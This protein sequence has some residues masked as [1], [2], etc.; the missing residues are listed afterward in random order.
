MS[1]ADLTRR[2]ATALALAALA[3]PAAAAKPAAKSP[4]DRRFEALGARYIDILTRSS[5]VSATQ[6]GEH[7]Y[8]RLVDDLSAAGRNRT[9][10]QNKA[11][12]A[13]VE[14]INAAQLSRANQVDLALLK[15]DLKRN[16]WSDEVLQSWAWDPQIYNN[17]A[18]GALYS[19]MAR[20]FAPRPQRIS[21]AISRM[22]KVPALL[23]Q[24]R[25]ELQP[26]RAPLIHAQTVARQNKGI[27]SIVDEMITPH[28]GEL[29]A[30]EQARFK[31]A[32]K[33]LRA[34]VAEHQTWLDKTLVPQA[35]GDFRLGAKMFDA[36][37]AF[38]LNS[39]MSRAEIRAAAE[40]ALKAARAEMFA[41]SKQLLGANAP[42]GADEQKTIEAG[43]ALVTRDHPPKAELFNSARA[44][45]REAEAFLRR[46]G[47]IITMPDSP[48]DVIEM[49]EFQR[50]VS[51]A[52]CDSPGP[53]EPHLKTFYAIAPIPTDWTDAQ[54]E[55]FL[56][57]YNRLAEHD[58]G[59]H[60][61]MPGH[62]VQLW[63]ANR[64]PSTLRAVLQSGT[65]VEGWGCY[66]EDMM[67]KNG[68]LD[69]D[70]KFRLQVLKTRVRTITN[71][72]L[73]QMMHVDGASRDEVMRFLTVT[74][75]Q[76]ER[77]AAGKFVRAQ[78]SSTQLSTY[79]VGVTEHDELR[80]EGERRLGSRFNLKAYH[81]KA[82]S[83]GSP[84][85][86][87]VRALM[88]DQPIT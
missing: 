30:A 83:Y 22:E 57:E 46:R 85:V 2:G 35:K 71:A 17:A 75:F 18:G 66:A 79:F 6:L 41:I 38:S 53:L 36:K 70:A 56:R 1:S 87:Y 49:P 43:L 64:Y 88:F 11:L 72:I 86:R 31:A 81:D 4:Q 25:T 52:Y 3:S 67:S 16:I 68:Y 9:L 76:E 7:R 13:Q 39:T 42:A 15:S 8:D 63:H 27:V 54:A 61:A 65:F 5:P 23:G 84:P 14:A 20:E 48:I 44:A 37:L 78:L 62:Y 50:G 73:D 28:V 12:L 47:D 45:M 80:A 40:K 59:V 24:A 19:L 51:V 77:E 32:D 21:A 26:A 60:E 55:S 82:L 33:A 34:A 58:I 69:G 74:A 10:A 29:S